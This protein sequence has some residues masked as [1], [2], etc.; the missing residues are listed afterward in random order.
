[1]AHG[2]DNER[3]MDGP[4]YVAAVLKDKT[5]KDMMVYRDFHESDN[6]AETMEA[7]TD[8]AIDTGLPV[9]VFD[10]YENFIIHRFD[11]KQAA[12]AVEREEAAKDK[13]GKRR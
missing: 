9:L 3:P 7:A 4:R 13:K 6:K 11:P 10:R 12:E 8:E 5:R 1:M 2:K